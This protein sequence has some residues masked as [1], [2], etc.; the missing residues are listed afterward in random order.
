MNLLIAGAS[1]FIGKSLFSKLNTEYK[2]TALN[3][4][5]DDSHHSFHSLDLTNKSDIKFFFENSLKYDVLI[6]LVGLA[7]KKG[8]GKDLDEFMVINNQT[9]INLLSVLNSLN[10]LPEKIIFSSTIS[11]YGEQYSQNHYFEDS[12]KLPLSPYAISKFKAEQY[13]LKYFKDTTWILRFAPVYSQ[14]FLLNIDRRTKIGCYS[15]RVG[16]GKYKLSLCNIENIA[17]VIEGIIKN[18]IPPEIYNLSDS[19][20]YTYAELLQWRKF[21]RYIPIPVFIIKLFYY[22]GK[23]IHNT[24]L[25]ENSIKLISNNLY[26]SKKIRA[27]V[28]LPSTI[29]DIEFDYDK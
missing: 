11:I 23:F 21:R 14:N 1:G 5:N 7:H 29:Y 24:F 20:N 16:Q 25:I 12:Y 28:D 19:K 2:I 6:F 18:K 9:L 3:Y 10:K 15:F 13:L 22:L 27:F 8:K 17:V 26:S 4:R